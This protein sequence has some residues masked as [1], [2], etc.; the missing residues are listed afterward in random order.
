[1]SA[2][3]L[4]PKQFNTERSIIEQGNMDD[5]ATRVRGVQNMTSNVY[6]P[7]FSQDFNAVHSEPSGTAFQT[8]ESGQSMEGME[9]EEA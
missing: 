8:S 2:G 1:M 9:D 5:L 4:S 3:A 6:K 7:A